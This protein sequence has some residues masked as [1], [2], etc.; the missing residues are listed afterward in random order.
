[1]QVR[2]STN[3]RSTI[4]K[5]KHFCLYNSYHKFVKNKD[6]SRAS[7]KDISCIFGKVIDETAD[8]YT[9][10]NSGTTD[11]QE[12]TVENEIGSNEGDVNDNLSY[13]PEEKSKKK[14]KKKRDKDFI[15]EQAEESTL[16]DLTILKLEETLV[17]GEIKIKK[18]KK[19]NKDLNEEPTE[20]SSLGDLTIPKPEEASEEGETKI[21]KKKKR[22]KHLSEEAMDETRLDDSDANVELT[23]LV[24]ESVPLNSEIS[25]K[26]KKKRSKAS[27]IEQLQEEEESV[28]MAEN[29]V[30]FSEEPAP[31]EEIA[32][33]E[34]DVKEKKRKKKKSKD[35]NGEKCIESENLVMTESKVH[36]IVNI[37]EEQQDEQ[38]SEDKLVKKEKKKSKKRKHDNSQ[39]EE[40]TTESHNPGQQSDLVDSEE[41]VN[42]DSERK[43]KKKKRKLDL[44]ENETAKQV[45]MTGDVSSTNTTN[46]TSSNGD[47]VENFGSLTF[48]NRGSLHDYFRNKMLSRGLKCSM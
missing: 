24:E 18:K 40:T 29:S 11:Q 2:S 5:L 36:E 33:D 47:K 46:P 12:P 7:T 6:L 35:K 13:S 3:I 27:E 28:N 9:I 41:C 39:E 45:K 16:D 1:M 4:N 44:D 10:L 17:G 23:K 42:N 43:K 48:I 38:E 8:I 21:K 19:R 20:E 32:E 14:K 30:P 34:N 15:E 37:S 26:K 25:K 22:D 31:K